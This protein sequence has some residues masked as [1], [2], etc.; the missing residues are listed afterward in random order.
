MACN[1]E[2]NAKP[3]ASATTT[4]GAGPPSTGAH[5][6]GQPPPTAPATLPG[7]ECRPINVRGKVHRSD[8]SALRKN[9]SLHGRVWL[10]LEEGAR[11]N[12]KD[13]SS[14]REW[15]LVGPAKVLPCHRGGEEVLLARGRVETAPTTGV[16]P[17]AESLISTPLG[18]VRYGD[19]RADIVMG[20]RGLSVLVGKGRVRVIPADGATL[21][22]DE[23][24]SGPRGK[25]TVTAPPAVTR[26]QARL[27]T[28]QK[29]AENAAV[30][31]RAVISG[32]KDAGKLGERAAAHVGLRQKARA[33]CSVAGAALGA[34]EDPEELG[35][36]WP[37]LD[38]AHA[39]WTAVPNAQK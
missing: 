21:G 2:K 18:A 30:G 20:D 26:P 8:G 3:V 17:G 10:T 33:A 5:G 14:G 12:I 9:E 38:R 4:L 24:L 28:C 15:T 6:H 31:A 27:K 25:A 37:L 11:V 7:A 35:R 16:R 1:D 34:L 32:G 39:S 23:N 29:A 19:A 36:L 22:G 13:T